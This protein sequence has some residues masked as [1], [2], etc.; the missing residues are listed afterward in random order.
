MKIIYALCE[1]CR[2][3]TKLNCE[4]EECYT[5]GY[6]CNNCGTFNP[7]ETNNTFEINKQ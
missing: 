6:I 7:Y 5:R 1:K 3:F 2:S 4:C